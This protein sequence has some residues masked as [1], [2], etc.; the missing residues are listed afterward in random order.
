MHLEPQVAELL[1]RFDLPLQA[2]PTD[3]AQTTVGAQRC[4]VQLNLPP[5]LGQ[6]REAKTDV[7]KGVDQLVGARLEVD[8]PFG[9]GENRAGSRNSASV[10]FPGGWLQ[11]ECGKVPRLVVRARQI[12]AG[13]KE[14]YLSTLEPPA[15]QHGCRESANHFLRVEKRLSAE[16]LLRVENKAARHK[17]GPRQQ[18]RSQGAELDRP[19]QLPLEGRAHRAV[20]N[21]QAEQPGK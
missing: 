3:F 1:R 21:R 4:G 8:A 13:L 18:L 2:E 20:K 17:R 14:I 7:G 5:A 9:H 15:P 12:D 10:T 11:Q 6:R 19:A 16:T